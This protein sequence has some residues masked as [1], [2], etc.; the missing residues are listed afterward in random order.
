MSTDLSQHS[1]E[2]LRNIELRNHAILNTA[3]D[4]IITIDHEGTVVEFN[5]AAERTF[6]YT[7]D[8]ALGRELAE[9]IIPE[10][11]REMHRKGIAKYLE[12]GIGPV[13]GT[14]VEVPALHADGHEFPVELAV[15]P[16]PVQGP[17]MFT[18]YVR[19]ITERKNAEEALRRHT[20]D[21]EA[22]RNRIEQ[23]AAEL[24]EQAEELRDARD[25]ALEASRAKS[26]FLANMSHELRTPLNA[27]I[28]YSEM[29]ADEVCEIADEVGPLAS[30]WVPD[31]K[32]IHTAGKHLLSLIN[33]I[34]DLSKIE[35][36]KMEVHAEE[37]DIFSTIR[38]VVSTIRPLVEEKGNRLVFTGDTGM[39]RMRADLTKF[40]QSLFNLL[41]NAGK[42]T[43]EGEIVLSARGERCDDSEWVVIEVSDTGIGMTPDQMDRLF[44][45][46]TQADSST[47]R[48]YG[49]TGLGLAI[50]R[51]FCQMMG[52]DVSV[53]SEVGEGSTFTLRLP[54][55]APVAEES[56]DTGDREETTLYPAN[57]A[58]RD[59]VLVIDDDPTVHHLMRR[60]LTREGYHVEV[61]AGGREGLRRMREL[62]P[63]AVTLDVMMPGTDGWS[64]LSAM[65]ND[66]Q[67]ADIPV[68]LVTMVDD[69]K[70]GFSLGA[71]DFMLKP[72]DRDGLLRVLGRYRGRKPRG[73]VLV[74]EDDVALR[75]MVAS[76]LAGDGW[77]VQE[78]ENGRAALSRVEE[79]AP[80]LIILDLMMPEVDGF[81]FL[82]ELRRSESGRAIPVIVV[83]AMDLTQSDRARLT[84]SV[85]RILLKG[86]QG[87]A[88][89]LQEV[90]DLVGASVKRCAAVSRE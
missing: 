10:S 18:A 38:E 69:R 9:L 1:D 49:G 85:E 24:A 90:R 41:S 21:V 47:T 28:G 5:P 65:K 75:Q 52:G 81:G 76:I 56:A 44:N 43:R 39:G 33:D 54:R 48:K 17:P 72:V 67:L 7:R 3:L 19:D 23:Q 22:A 55:N 77:T 40:R 58:D 73:S 61:A 66:P 30:G 37:F 13:L 50:T 86:G 84:G 25:Q 27:I 42:F 64:V 82:S 57:P 34:L 71:S 83:T 80:D 14:R 59:T 12:T 15:N 8:Q 36:G 26:A 88:H 62:R 79:S 16:I 6:G 60:M 32:K 11:L 51:R 78:A 63:A 74:V 45:E 87:R 20:A 89:L 46:F 53:A 29:L 31:L 4:C 70:L 35:A 2:A 68:I